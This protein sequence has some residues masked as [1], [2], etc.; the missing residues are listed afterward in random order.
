MAR[1]LILMLDSVGI[2][3]S[4]DAEQF[5][6]A[7]ANTLGHIAQH[8][9]Q[10]KGDNSGR[11]GALTLPNLNALGIGH[12]CR[13]ASGLFPPGLNENIPLIGAYAHAQEIS[14]GKDTPSGHWEMAGV[15]VRFEWG[16]FPKETDTFPADLLTRIIERAQLPGILGNCRASGTEII[17]RLGEEHMQSG[18]PIFYTSVDSVFQIAAHEETFGLER[19]YALCE[20]VFEELDG[21]NIGRVI[22]RPFIGSHAGNFKRTGNRHD[23]AIKP[24]STTILEKIIRE[25]GGEVH[26]VG[27]IA[28]IYANTGISHSNRA[29]G[30]AQLFD[31]TLAVMDKAGDN[32]LIFT[33]FVDFDSEYGHR[34]DVP[35]Y[36]GALEYFDRRLPELLG[37]LR[38]DDLLI[39]TADH[40]NDPTWHGTEHTREY[41]P[42]LLHGDGVPAGKN[43]GRR[44]TFA[45]IA[46]TLAQRFA[47]SPMPDGTT[48]LP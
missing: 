38:S 7:G 2:G 8:C 41:V 3:S 39:I 31:T 43:L 15:P 42:I 32:S 13:D 47:T 9:A 22:A 34:R 30:L 37:K 25:A 14:T 36:A 35:G 45:D 20:I 33:N 16:Y 21:M 18:K 28:D 46:Q 10:G 17:A 12:A 48:L 6:D 11:R 29:S 40:G 19:L 23:Y 4:P 26:S 24:P 27:K 1:T 5:G 44:A